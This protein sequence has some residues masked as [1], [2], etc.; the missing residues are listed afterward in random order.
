[1]ANRPNYVIPD[2][3][4]ANDLRLLNGVFPIAQREKDAIDAWIIDPESAGTSYFDFFWLTSEIGLSGGLPTLVVK[5]PRFFLLLKNAMEVYMCNEGA[6]KWCSGSHNTKR[7][8]MLHSLDSAMRS[9]GCA[10][11]WGQLK[12]SFWA[13][14][15]MNDTDAR[16]ERLEGRRVPRRR[17][18]VF[19]RG[20]R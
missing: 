18:R 3:E 11:E 19:R 4:A 20:R 1:M 14:D 16:I 6:C 2:R 13:R 5:N 9:L 17:N 15:L 10:G 8:P 12:Y 7:C